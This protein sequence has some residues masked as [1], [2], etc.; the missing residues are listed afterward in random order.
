MRKL[1]LS[2]G[3]WAR[4]PLKL[5]THLQRQPFRVPHVS[6]IHRH[7]AL[8]ASKLQFLKIPKCL[9]C[10]LCFSQK[11]FVLFTNVLFL[12]SLSSSFLVD[13][14]QAKA[15]RTKN[16][17]MLLQGKLNCSNGSQSKNPWLW[18]ADSIVPT[19]ALSGRGRSGSQGLW[20]CAGSLSLMWAASRQESWGWYYKQLQ[21]AADAREG[22]ILSTHLQQRKRG[23]KQ[24]YT[25]FLR[26]LQ[27]TFS[28][29][30]CVIRLFHSGRNCALNWNEPNRHFRLSE[31][32]IFKIFLTNCW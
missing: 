4:S 30:E 3:A 27:Q 21:A 6:H 24:L 26:A 28:S 7:L 2:I 18:L 8:A 20:G 23:G 9:G 31:I 1:A 5:S 14:R 16:K 12:R 15:E 19:S 17:K 10:A 25:I 13:T 29:F 32:F 22:T 11:Q